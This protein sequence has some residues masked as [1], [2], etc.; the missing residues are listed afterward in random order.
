MTGGGPSV[1]WIW[2]ASSC[3]LSKLAGCWK[4][5]FHDVEGDC[6]VSRAGPRSKV[7]LEPPLNS[8]ACRKACQSKCLKSSDTADRL[9]DPRAAR[10]GRVI[11]EAKR[12]WSHY[13]LLDVRKAF[14]ALHPGPGKW[15]GLSLHYQSMRLCGFAEQ[16]ALPRPNRR[17]GPDHH[18][19][20]H[21]ATMQPWRTDRPGSGL[22]CISV[23][24]EPRS[25]SF[26]ASC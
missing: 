10:G 8:P 15:S 13:F 1:P 26:S 19:L 11:C 4:T 22:P 17:P 24:G 20:I 14:R 25:R 5:T 16:I 7:H 21:G 6:H 3:V 18:N 2:K 12:I 9:I 23:H